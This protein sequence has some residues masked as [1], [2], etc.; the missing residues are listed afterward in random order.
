MSNQRP[1]FSVLAAHWNEGNFKVPRE[2]LKAVGSLIFGD[3]FNW[4][5]PAPGFLKV[6]YGK[7]SQNVGP[8]PEH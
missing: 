6:P 8:G 7:A 3:C 1:S 4:V 5:Q 2:T